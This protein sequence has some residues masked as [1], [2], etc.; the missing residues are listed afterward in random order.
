MRFATMSGRENGKIVEKSDQTGYGGCRKCAVSL[1][2]YL[3]NSNSRL[4][5]A[6]LQQCRIILSSAFG[7]YCTYVLLMFLHSRSANSRLTTGYQHRQIGIKQS[8]FVMNGD[9]RLQN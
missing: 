7:R 2:R 1:A 3:H 4:S 8:L 5:M 9:V 6:Q